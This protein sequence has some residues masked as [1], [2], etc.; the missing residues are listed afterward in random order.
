MTKKTRNIIVLIFIFFFLLVGSQLIF[1]SLGYRFDFETKKIV[2]TG[3][4][5]L[6]VWPPVAEIFVDGKLKEKTGIIINSVLIQNLLPKKHEVLIKKEG[7]Y[8]WKKN[9][10][11]REREVTRADNVVL[12]KENPLFEIFKEKVNDFFFSPD[13]KTIVL[14]KSAED[15]FGLEIFNLKKEDNKKIF[16][17]S[18][19]AKLLD[20]KWSEDSKKLLVKIEADKE[21]E[22][23]LIDQTANQEPSAPLGYLDKNTQ[24]IS[25]NPANSKEIFFVKNGSLYLKNEK[26]LPILNKV[27][28]YTFL[29]N[30]II[31]LEKSGNV[32][33]S[34]FSGN[35][36]EVLNETPFPVKKDGVYRV[37]AHLNIIFILENEVLYT[38]DTKTKEFEKLYSPVKELMLSPDNQKILY[39][40][41]YEISF[42][43][44]TSPELERIFLTRFS[45]K[46]EDCSW[47][48]P[49]YLVFRIGDTIKISETDTRDE[50]NMVDLVKL[51]KFSKDYQEAEKLTL[52]LSKTKVLWNG[53]VKKLYFLITNTL[54]ASERLFP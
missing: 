32:L 27:T 46:N 3:G 18:H 11:V 49:S 17:F 38:L 26:I 53:S 9:L 21:I 52:T 45:E 14:K 22:Y 4:L 23:F 33:R 40:N 5:Y 54:F 6:K 28:A 19:N 16:S 39:L 24:E 43:D 15:G 44:L 37:V 51:G 42:S 2:N 48:N 35:K 12:I 8:P 50:I 34:D 31:W 25:F 30:N 36:I 41:D 29:Q 13:Q 7:Y 47:L 1:Y 20:L 10:D